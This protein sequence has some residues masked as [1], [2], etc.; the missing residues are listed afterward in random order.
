[1]MNMAEIRAASREQ[2][3]VSEI[4]LHI[5]DA[6]EYRSD[7]KPFSESTYAGRDSMQP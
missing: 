4:C 1:M 3:H 2:V 5:A 6:S 7:A